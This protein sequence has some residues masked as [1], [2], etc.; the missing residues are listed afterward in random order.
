MAVGLEKSFVKM[1]MDQQKKAIKDK[2]K[3]E[4]Q[5]NHPE[6]ELVIPEPIIAPEIHSDGYI[7][8]KVDF[9]EGLSEDNSN[10][11]CEE[12]SLSES[13]EGEYGEYGEEEEDPK[14]IL[15]PKSKGKIQHYEEEEPTLQI[16]PEDGNRSDRS[17]SGANQDK[18]ITMNVYQT[19]YDV[20]KKCGRKICNWRLKNWEEDHYGAVRNG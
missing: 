4:N 1:I 11:W 9:N 7:D 16:E 12:A 5:A 19:E 17:F 15:V 10:S 18:R 20:V 8:H 13:D 3:A 14:A 2:I 6:E